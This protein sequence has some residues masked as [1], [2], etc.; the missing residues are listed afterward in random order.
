MFTI[1]KQICLILNIFLSY[2][3]FIIYVLFYNILKIDN[4]KKNF[5]KDKK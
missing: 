3:F 2:I 5:T 4:N 1:K